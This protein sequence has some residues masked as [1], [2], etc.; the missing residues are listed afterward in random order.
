MTERD[1]NDRLLRLN[2]ALDGELDAMASLAFERELRD[3]PALAAEYRRLAAL[4]DAIRRHA[5]RE[6]APQAL[7]D[8]IAAL[9]ASAATAPAPQAAAAPTATV[10]P[11]RRRAWLDSR[12]LAMAASFAVLG[13]AVGAGLTSLRTPA[14]SPDVA[15]HLV[16]DFARAEIAGQPFDV[17]SSDRHTVKPWLA[18]RTTVSASIVDLAAEGFPLVGRTRRRR[19]PDPAPTL[20]YRHNEHVVAV[21]ELPLDAKGVRAALAESKRSTAITS[22]AG[23]TRTS[24]MSPF[25]TWTRRRSANSSRRSG[26]A[27]ARRPSRPSPDAL[28]AGPSSGMALGTDARDSPSMTAEAS[29]A[30]LAAARSTPNAIRAEFWLL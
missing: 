16:S 13:F 21:T 8:R 20:V 3:D 4:R 17:A 7:A 11:F 30:G 15:Q 28:A 27:A 6:A 9:T 2:A 14:G 18:D 26:V 29:A 10:V 12:A 19:G 24:P 22:R 25:P 5:P 1:A 23:P